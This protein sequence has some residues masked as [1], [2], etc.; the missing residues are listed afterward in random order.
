M[1]KSVSL[2][3]S[4]HNLWF[5]WVHVT[6]NAFLAGVSKLAAFRN[7]STFLLDVWLE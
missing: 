2:I 5:A 6:L 3:H 4:K 7:F 1:G